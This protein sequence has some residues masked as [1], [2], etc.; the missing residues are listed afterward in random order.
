MNNL[1]S[2]LNDHLGGS[3]AALELIDYLG[4]KRTAD[5]PRFAAFLRTLH[6]D[7]S[8]DQERL[9]ELIR[10]FSE[11][12]LLR[13]AAGWIGEKAGRVKLAA[14]GVVPGE[15]GLLEALEF[16]ALGITG[17]RLLWGA[18]RAGA[19]GAVAERLDLDELERRAKHQFRRVEEWRRK[20]A[21]GALGGSVRSFPP[22]YRT[23]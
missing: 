4:E 9:R 7:V 11:E 23:K 21:R 20:T 10:S 15:L 22:N 13:K 14:A 6:D 3:V 17:K 16:L 1:A 12:S 5:N 19:N 2:Y 18:L 8:Q